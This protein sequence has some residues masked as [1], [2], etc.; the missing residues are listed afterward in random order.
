VSV[1][2]KHLLVL[3]DGSAAGD[4][5]VRTASRLAAHDHARLTVVAVAEVERAARCCGFGTSTWND[6]LRDAAAAD[7]ERA[8]A[9]VESPAHFAV[10][11]GERSQAVAEAASELGCDAIMI[12]RRPGR[13]ARLL[14]RD[15]VTAVRRRAGCVVIP[16]GR[17]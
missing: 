7:L 4:A 16:S 12:A 10:L 17:E 3:C 8:R 14:T 1:A 15:P 6:V 9:V 11:C 2:Y 5:A 13:L